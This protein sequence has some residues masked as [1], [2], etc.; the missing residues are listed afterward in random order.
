MS[1]VN[2][3]EPKVTPFYYKKNVANLTGRIGRS[4]SGIQLPDWI[5]NLEADF[6]TQDIT[7]DKDKIAEARSCVDHNKGSARLII[8][9][10]TATTWLEYKKEL[11]Q[12]FGIKIYD[13]EKHNVEIGS[14]KWE[15]DLTFVEYAHQMKTA[16]DRRIASDGTMHESA[17]QMLYEVAESNI[18]ANM[19]KKLEEKVRKLGR[20]SKDNKSFCTFI[21]KCQELLVDINYENLD[22]HSVTHVSEEKKEKNIK[23]RQQGKCRSIDATNGSN[24]RGKEKVRDERDRSLSQNVKEMAFRWE[25]KNNRCSRCLNKGHA[26]TNC[27]E[28]PFC[29]ICKKP[30]NEYL[31][32][33]YRRG[34]SSQN[35]RGQG[36]SRFPNRG[37]GYN[38]PNTRGGYHGYWENQGRQEQFPTYPGWQN[39]YYNSQGSQQYGYP[40]YNHIPYSQIPNEAL[41]NNNNNRHQMAIPK[42]KNENR[43]VRCTELQPPIT[44]EMD[45]QNQEGAKCLP[46]ADRNQNPAMDF[47]GGS[48]MTLG[49]FLRERY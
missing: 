16:I 32:C 43:E 8:D 27:R 1:V 26:R 40:D 30:G 17:R 25:T 35:F 4:W 45:G 47:L 41:N 49:P 20:T 12:Q 9:L 5:K 6:A 10:I 14:L 24:P 34:N 13:A 38:N 37:R 11:Y 29:S 48:G 23:G 15:R 33:Y 31:N 36:N 39:Q 44:T 46:E 7:A 3:M 21:R 28:V 42:R 19:P 2:R 22:A 18:K